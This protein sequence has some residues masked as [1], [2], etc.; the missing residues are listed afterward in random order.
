MC[1]CLVI[2]C[3][4]RC[5]ITNATV[6]NSLPSTLAYGQLMSMLLRSKPDQSLTFSDEEYVARDELTK[7]L[8][9]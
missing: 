2:T 9:I 1:Q 6:L 7:W 3:V 5:Y 4:L 8:D